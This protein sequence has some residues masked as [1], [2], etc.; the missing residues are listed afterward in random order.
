M[1]YLEELKIFRKKR[2]VQSLDTHHRM[3]IIC[4]Q[5]ASDISDPRGYHWDFYMKFISNLNRLKEYKSE[6]SSSRRESSEKVS[7]NCIFLQKRWKGHQSLEFLDNWTYNE[8]KTRRGWINWGSC[9]EERGLWTTLE[10]ILIWYA[11]LWSKVLLNLQSKV[12]A[13]KTKHV[14]IKAFRAS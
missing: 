7:Q 4:E 5:I 3:L 13:T 14:E 9:K 2:Q 6:P 10:D 1:K 12:L 11:F 8:I